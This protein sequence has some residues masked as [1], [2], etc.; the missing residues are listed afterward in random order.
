MQL[1]CKTQLVEHHLHA[2]IVCSVVNQI[3]A[4]TLGTTD[5]HCVHWHYWEK[6]KQRVIGLL[7]EIGLSVSNNESLQSQTFVL[8]FPNCYNNNWYNSYI[9]ILIIIM[10][11]NERWVGDK[12]IVFCNP[13]TSTILHNNTTILYVCVRKIVNFPLGN[14]VVLTKTSFIS[15]KF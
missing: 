8:V 6:L 14:S 1:T 9:N 4:S 3:T 12:V 15:V 11:W 5:Q 13:S 2:V 10:V 7:I